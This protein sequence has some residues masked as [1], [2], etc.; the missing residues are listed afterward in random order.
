[1]VYLNAVFGI[2]SSALRS[3]TFFNA[4]TS[5]L[6]KKNSIYIYKKY[7]QDKLYLSIH[8]IRKGSK[9]VVFSR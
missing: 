5:P 4:T 1:M 9:D 6:C 8:D 3:G 2:P 7:I